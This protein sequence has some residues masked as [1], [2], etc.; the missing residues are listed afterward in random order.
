MEVPLS[1]RIDS[2]KAEAAE[3][4]PELKADTAQVR[5]RSRMPTS[6][7]VRAGAPREARRRG[8]Q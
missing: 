7:G 2:V 3:F 6:E 8:V 5:A 4:K 1:E